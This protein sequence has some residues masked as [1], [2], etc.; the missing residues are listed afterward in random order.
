[1]E[2]IIMRGVSKFLLATTLILC[3]SCSTVFA[4]PDTA[5]G[6]DDVI[7]NNTATSEVQN[8]TSKNSETD[9]QPALTQP[10]PT[11]DSKRNFL[12]GIN[13]AADLSP[14]VEGVASA[15]QPLKKG[16]AFVV[17]ILSYVIVTGMAL[18]VVLDLTYIAV[19]P[20]RSFLSNGYN[21]TP[22]SAAGAPGMPGSVGGFGGGQL[23]SGFGNTGFNTGFNNGFNSGYNRYGGA[24]GTNGGQ[25]APQPRNRIQLVSQAALDAVSNE[26]GLDPQSGKRK[27]V[28]GSYA[29]RMAPMLVAVPILLVLAVTGSL[30]QLGFLIADLLV[31]G[32]ASLG[33]MLGGMSF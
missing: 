12:S 8:N 19:T 29:K 5:Q 26:G 1:M 30:T 2:G 13:Q 23:N 32:I 11:E 21:G 10:V 33:E 28:I 16:V 25:A 15:T 4:D 20:L 14:E 17:Q 31:D 6:L 9:S 3:L 18:S 27:G 7:N 22:Q 24:M